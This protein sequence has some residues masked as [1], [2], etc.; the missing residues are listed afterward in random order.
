LHHLLP[1]KNT[2]KKKP[3]ALVQGP[4][5]VVILLRVS[6]TSRT[7]THRRP[8]DSLR[9]LSTNRLARSAGRHDRPAV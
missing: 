4:A 1:R 6:A 2:D 3:A 8:A 9:P 5:G 7:H